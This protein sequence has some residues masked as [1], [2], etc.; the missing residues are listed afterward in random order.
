LTTHEV[1]GSFT[2]Q[3]SDDVLNLDEAGKAKFVNLIAKSIAHLLG[4]QSGYVSVIVQNFLEDRRLLMMTHQFEGRRLALTRRLAT[5]LEVSYTVST[6]EDQASSITEGLT[7]IVATGLSDT[8]NSFIA[9]D[10]TLS[11]IVYS[12]TN[13]AAPTVTAVGVSL[14]DVAADESHE[15]SLTSILVICLFVLGLCLCGCMGFLWIRG[16]TI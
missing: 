14:T 15:W 8:L 5:D 7:S 4:I 13:F 6:T 12:I 10:G 1:S 2:M 16:V 9:E 11:V 3:A